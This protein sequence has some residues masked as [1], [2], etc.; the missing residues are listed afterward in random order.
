MRTLAAGDRMCMSGICPP[1]RDPSL[2]SASE[3]SQVDRLD[4]VMAAFSTSP[5]PSHIA[6]M[7][8]HAQLPSPSS[9]SS[10]PFSRNVRKHLKRVPKAIM[11]SQRVSL[12]KYDLPIRLRPVRPPTRLS[13]HTQPPF[14]R[15]GSFSLHSRSCSSLLSSDSPACPTLYR[16]TTRS[17]ISPASALPPACSTSSST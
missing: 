10:S 9:P 15:S 17:S 11:K 12:P 4:S 13:H 5:L 8:V 2:M 14:I 7:A 16:S 3:I 6:S 1:C